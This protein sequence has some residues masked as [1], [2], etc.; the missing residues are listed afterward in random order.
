ML[1]C[2]K[3]IANSSVELL[4]DA[5]MLAYARTRLTCGAMPGPG[6]NLCHYL[7]QDTDPRG[8]NAGNTP[9]NWILC[10]LSSWPMRAAA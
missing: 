7:D 6:H 9:A 10:L 2:G 5:D 3:I 4:C 8:L 1:F